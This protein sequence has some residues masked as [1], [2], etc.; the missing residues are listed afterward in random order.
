ML[1]G[2]CNEDNNPAIKDAI[3]LTLNTSGEII[4]ETKI[5]DENYNDYAL[6][7][8]A[9][10]E[11]IYIGGYGESKVKF[12]QACLLS[13]I[14]LRGEVFWFE[15]IDYYST[16]SFNDLSID[17]QN[18]LIAIGSCKYNYDYIFERM[19][20]A[21]TKDSDNDI[22][23][24]KF[25]LEIGTD[26]E[27]PD[28]DSDGYTDGEEYLNYTDPLKASSNPRNML[29]LRNLAITIFSLLVITFSIIQ[30][31]SKTFMR[32]K[33]SSDKSAIIKFYEKIRKKMMIRKRNNN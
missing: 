20:L 31:Y 8:T 27:N 3:L 23:S 14:S 29:I 30:F 33:D 1:A 11:T 21:I 26:P 5:G 4:S 16:S 19:L 24:D 25:E 18:Q 2:Q 10:N 7:V 6:S 15:K 28:T 17:S 22:L 32:K 13:K 12:N 9:K